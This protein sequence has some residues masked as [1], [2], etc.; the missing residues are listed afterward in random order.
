MTSFIH[1]RRE[2]LCITQG[3]EYDFRNGSIA[4]EARALLSGPLPLRPE[5]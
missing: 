5:S 1:F 3:C 4:T 2:L